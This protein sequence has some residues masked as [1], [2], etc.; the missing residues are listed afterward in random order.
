MSERETPWP[1]GFTGLGR[2]FE[3]ASAL[4]T[5]K[6]RDGRYLFANTRFLEAVGRAAGEV[7]GRDDEAL[8][9]PVAAAEVAASD[10]RVWESGEALEL[11]QRLPLA[12]GEQ[13]YLTVK[14]PVTG[15]SGEPEA[16]CAVAVDFTE[17]RQMRD[18]LSNVAFGVSAATGGNVFREIVRY[19]ARTLEV[20]FAFVG[21]LTGEGRQGLATLAVYDRG[22]IVE[23]IAY[24]L[25]GTPCERVVG[26]AFHYIPDGVRARFPGDTMLSRLGFES[27]AGYPLYDSGGRALGLIAVT[28]RGPLRN[29]P[30][31]ESILR[32]FSVRAAAEL[33][34]LRSEQERRI[35]EE[36]YRAI[37]EAAEDAIFV[38]D[39]D[40]GA[41]VDVNPKAC[42]A[43]GYDHDELL[44]V[45]PGV[46]SSGR[47]PYTPEEAAARIRRA[48]EGETLRFEW[49]RRNKDGTL[50]WD[51]VCLKRASIGGTPRVIAMTREISQRRRAEAL[52]RATVEASLDCIVGMDM[53]GRVVEFNAAAERVFGYRRE[54][55]IGRPLADLMIPERHR[56]AHHAGMA[57]YRDEGTGAVLN[58]RMEVEACRA[59]GSEFPAELTI[60]SAEGE[61]GDLF[62]GY[63]RD[64]SD[65]RRAEGERER[66]EAQLRQA[67]KMEAIGHLTGGIAHDFNNILTGIMG[68][69][70]LAE[71][72]AGAAGDD[73]LVRYLG[74]ARRSG[75]RARDLIQQML[76][77]SRGRKGEPRALSLTPVVR[78]AVRLLGPMLPSSIEI[79]TRLE[80][81][82]PIVMVDPVHVEQVVM[83]LCI[84]ARDAM[85][86]R[87]ALHI[88]LRRIPGLEAVCASCRRQVTGDHVV[89]SVGDSGEG[90]AP[91][92]LERMFEPFFSTKGVGKGSGMGLATVHGIVH[93]HGGHVLVDTAV[94][95]GTTLRVLLPVA[96]AAAQGAVALAEGAAGDPQRTAP[97]RGRLLLADDDRDVLELMQ[98]LL[99]EWG[100][101][102]TAC[103]NG[104]EACERFAED[105]ERYDLALLD[106]TMPRMTGLEVARCLL[107]QRPSLPVLL[108]SGYS[109]ALSEE[110]VAREGIRALLRKPL[111]HAAL[112]A[113]LERLLPRP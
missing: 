95:R 11:E 99:A 7:L 102:V 31:V 8:L 49:H 17:R 85:H 25:A 5:V 69:V 108:Y 29:R 40:T 23:N 88:D 59:D 50:H 72:R 97:L 81:D 96:G 13:V 103:A 60:A 113:E 84:N 9:G 21:E 39:I 100:L 43:Y 64:I 80:T 53:D 62:I 76:T 57:R 48:R 6:G 26:Q 28:H 20:D 45:D 75:E 10:R 24:D 86:G 41:I 83:N 94:G 54:E 22:E 38:H 90:I 16:L 36:S 63:L 71:E 58:R 98:D 55:V 61:E 82:L 92:V 89:L 104:A 101:T 68:Y 42:Q 15:R 47:G 19:L 14:F 35:S 74:R 70:T 73:K 65:R 27:Y 18:A 109:E 46:L 77:F 111:D 91:E 3:R 1:G 12:G 105:P 52:L 2:L 44:G 87:G 34:R 79:E 66:L 33:E 93:E 110:S 32:I 78:E 4:V 51:E 56:A 106:Q 30:L 37:F 112:R 107:A 67:Q